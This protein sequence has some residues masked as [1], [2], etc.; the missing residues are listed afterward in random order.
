MALRVMSL[1][2]IRLELLLEAARSGACF[3]WAVARYGQPSPMLPGRH[4]RGRVDNV[5]NVQ[6]PNRRPRRS[7]SAAAS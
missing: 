4:G 7:W 2:E 6:V 3:E 1:S 5:W